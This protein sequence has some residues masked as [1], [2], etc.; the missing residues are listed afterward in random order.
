MYWL[1]HRHPCCRNTVLFNIEPIR[2]PCISIAILAALRHSVHEQLKISLSAVQHYKGL[3]QWVQSS[4]QPRW[5]WL[6][7]TCI[8]RYV[9]CHSFI[10]VPG[11]SATEIV[12]W[13]IVELTSLKSMS[14]YFLLLTVVIIRN[15]AHVPEWNHHIWNQALELTAVIS[16]NLCC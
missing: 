13:I 7:P 5:A 14:S 4:S 11:D 2:E 3:L 8:F 16:S 6:K 9:A 10:V 1:A 12:G 15:L